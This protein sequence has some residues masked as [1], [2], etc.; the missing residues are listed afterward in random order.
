MPALEKSLADAIL[1]VDTLWGGD[2]LN[3]S[4]TGR[5]IA[6]CWFSDEPLPPAYT[7]DAARRVRESGGVSAKAVDQEAIDAYLEVVDVQ[8]AIAAV[9]DYAARH[10]RPARAL[11]GLAGRVLRHHVG[12]GPGAARPRPGGALRALRAGHDRARARALRGGPQARARG[13]APGRG[14]LPLVDVRRAAGRG[15]RLARR[16]PGAEGLD[17]GPGR[18]LHRR[19]RRAHRPPRHAAPAG[20]AAGRAARQHRL[21]ADQGRLVLGLDE[22]PGPGPERRTAARSTRPPTRSTPRC[23][24][25]C[26]SSSSWSATRSCRAT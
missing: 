19:A 5:F 26:P 15:G 8:G 22:L 2:V 7:H 13:G 17:Q 14:R 25:P 18:R 21:P 24:S 9:A 11:A 16:A 23:R 12:P 6:D 20:R 3:P 4:G 10:R 1:G